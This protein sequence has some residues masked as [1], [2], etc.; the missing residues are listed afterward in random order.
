M[1]IA[2]LF[3]LIACTNEN[4]NKN[5]TDVTITFETNDTVSKESVTIKS[6]TL[7]SETELSIHDREDFTF[8]RLIY[9]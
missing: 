8:N 6:G 1:L 4:E 5:D 2:T 3:T 7:L 9:R